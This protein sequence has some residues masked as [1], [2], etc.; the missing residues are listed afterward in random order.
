[1]RYFK[2]IGGMINAV[3]AES[4]EKDDTGNPII[5]KE[6]SMSEAEYIRFK[7][8]TVKEIIKDW[9]VIKGG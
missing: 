4:G 8:K 9:K 2:T 3:L 5:A 6:K 7:K 1:M